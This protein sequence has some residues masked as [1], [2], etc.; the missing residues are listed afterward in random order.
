M[1]MDDDISRNGI[2]VGI[3]GSL[4]ATAGACWAATEAAMREV[5]FS[6]VHIVASTLAPWPAIGWPTAL[7]GQRMV[8]GTTRAE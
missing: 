3:D 5:P 7:D 1:T 8:T 4:E 2:V 6:L